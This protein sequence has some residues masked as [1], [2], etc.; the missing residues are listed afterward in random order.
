M[1]N[2][3]ENHI[4]ALI[5]LKKNII[6]KKR[7]LK[8]LKSNINYLKN[9]FYSM[10]QNI[11][12]LRNLY[13]LDQNDE[14]LKILDNLNESKKI[15]MEIPEVSLSML[16]NIS[17]S[18]LKFLISKLEKSLIKNNNLIAPLKL[19]ELIGLFYFDYKDVFIKSEI[20]ILDFL[21]EYFHPICVWDSEFHN[22]LKFIDDEKPKN[23]VSVTKDLID[24]LISSSSNSNASSIIV[25][26]RNSLPAFL[27]NI[28]ELIDMSQKPKQE[29]RHN[30]YKRLDVIKLLGFNNIIITLNKYCK[31]LVEEKIGASIYIKK[32]GNFMVIQGIFNDDLLDLSRTIEVVRNK[33]T[34]IKSIINY[35]VLIVP[36]TFK[37]NYLETLNLRDIIITNSQ[38]IS[39]DL[40]KKYAEYKNLQN[41]TLLALINEFLLGSKYRKIDILSLLLMNSEEDQKIAFILFD[42]LKSK[43]KKGI[44]NEIYQSLN[45][46][47]RVLLD[48]ARNIVQDAEANLGKI[49]LS[50]LPYERRINLMKTDD[51][52]KNK[53]IE[54]LKAMKSNM[55]GD[56]KAQA[57]LDGL[58]K[59][60][61]GIYKENPILNFKD[62]FVEK[63]NLL[64][65]QN[66]KS[67]FEIDNYI[68]NMHS[69]MR[70][71]NNN[72]HSINNIIKE[73]DD[74]Q[75]DKINYLKEVRR[76]LDKA[77][78]GHKEAKLQLERIFAQWINGKSK[79]AI[80]GL[81]GPP[82]TGKT[83]LAKNGL[84][85]CLKDEDGLSRPFAFLPIG[86]SVNGSTLVGH[87]YTYVGSTWGRIA[88][89]LMTSQC[90]NP[91][92]FIDEVDKIST[93]EH[94]REIVSI[95]THLTDLTQ[96]DEFEDKYFAGVKLDLSKALIVMSFNDVNLLDPILRDRITIIETNPLSLPEKI[97]IIKNY[98]LPEILE[99][100]G[101]NNN[102]IIFNDDLIKE[103]IE[104][105]TNEAGVRK[106]KEKITEI[107]RD[108]NLKRFH[109]RIDLPYTITMEYIKE[110]FED[111]P[112]VRVKKINNSP[113]I[114]LVN[115]LYATTSGIGGITVIQAMKYPSDKKLELHL[116]GKQGDVMKE[117]VN[118]ALKIAFSLLEEE[119]QNE[120]L[121][122]KSFGIHV[123]TPEAS[124]PKDG[125]SA[126]AAMTLALYSLLSGKKVNNKVALTGEIDL[127]KNVTAIGGVGAKLNGAKK[128]GVEIALLP[129]ENED[130][131]IKLRKEK[132][133]PEDDN[134]KVILVEH[135]DQVLEHGIINI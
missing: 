53:A 96:N 110:L 128:A 121:D 86:G 2:L 118:Y 126:G 134:F 60:P 40:I 29:L 31:S 130:D 64:E 15:L 10:V 44:S 36:K 11:S 25:S 104:T 62:K 35:D 97:I 48:N 73:W 132:L 21:F 120:I 109:E 58:L 91:I 17:I 85:K 19:K 135:I 49:N 116:T 115:G 14:S 82:G 26:D 94:G 41:K 57:W 125:P 54:K 87:N 28:T 122:G 79:G 133:S 69:N 129:K 114:G 1:D 124:V 98:M 55:Q 105:Y 12:F 71:N 107:I 111:K 66:L 89:I 27:R 112:K 93:T 101:F 117:S 38:E 3:D 74:Y 23:S 18:R 32:N 106:I 46:H 75:Q 42:V 63:I 95:L 8:Q 70:S 65:K 52:T 61:F 131:L 20:E 22:N 83:S 16:K 80:L 9:Y 77:V 5:L 127:C 103:I 51:D 119:K 88:D 92:I 72:I 100:V 7:E 102:E 43:D 45:H 90:M 30:T 78:Y 84:S 33:F 4:E 67:E 76:N 68:N 56:N 123:H 13:I 50:D 39:E 108:I 24:S 59:I 113:E 81:H 47:L 99:E 34:R 37:N 6:N